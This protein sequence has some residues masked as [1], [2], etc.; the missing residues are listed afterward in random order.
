MTEDEAHQECIQR[1]HNAF[2]KTVIRYAAIDK[3]LKLR[4]R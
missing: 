4:R 3:I 1:R 2:C